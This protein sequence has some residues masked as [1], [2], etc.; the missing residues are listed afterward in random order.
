MVK[1]KSGI[2]MGST[3]FALWAT[4][5]IAPEQRLYAYAAAPGQ[6]SGVG[7]IFGKIEGQKLATLRGN[8]AMGHS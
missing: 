8:A 1:K 2:W 5:V 6:T 3:E 4:N 7:Q